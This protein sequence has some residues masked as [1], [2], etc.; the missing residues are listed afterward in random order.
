MFHLE[1]PNGDDLET[2][3]PPLLESCE[4]PSLHPDSSN[5]PFKKWIQVWNIYYSS[6]LPFF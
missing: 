1:M 2:S 4:H 6:P 3:G 5:L